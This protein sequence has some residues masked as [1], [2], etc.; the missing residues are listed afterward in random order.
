[1]TELIECDKKYTFYFTTLIDCK[2]QTMVM[3]LPKH[4]PIEKSWKRLCEYMDN[5]LKHRAEDIAELQQQ[6]EGSK[7]LSS[8][9]GAEHATE[10]GNGYG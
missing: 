7:S 2:P 4:K 6:G 3:Q 5:Y 9:V 10:A 8:N 1:M